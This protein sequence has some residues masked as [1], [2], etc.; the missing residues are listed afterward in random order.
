MQDIERER[1][2]GGVRERERQ[3]D[4]DL[5]IEREKEGRREGGMDGSRCSRR[6]ERSRIAGQRS[7]GGL[8][9]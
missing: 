9:Q 2:G 1:E 8:C 3:R 7:P 4:I 6:T 5:A